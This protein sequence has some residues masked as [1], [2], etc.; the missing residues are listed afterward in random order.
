MCHMDKMS[1]QKCSC[2]CTLDALLQFGV[3][4]C[5][6]FNLGFSKSICMLGNCPSF[7]TFSTFVTWSAL[8]CWSLDGDIEV[9]IDV[10]PLCCPLML[11]N[12][13]TTHPTTFFNRFWPCILQG[14][15]VF[16]PIYCLV[17]HWLLALPPS[18]IAIGII[19]FYFWWFSPVFMFPVNH[20][21]FF[22]CFRYIYNGSGLAVFCIIPCRWF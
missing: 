21:L 4:A 18:L 17:I 10:N 20:K 2:T 15:W 1:C 8:K 13:S 3:V 9:G 11:W 14:F 16:V 5:N 12:L 22:Q 6:C 19:S 7:L